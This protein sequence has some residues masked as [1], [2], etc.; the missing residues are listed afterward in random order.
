MVNP[1]IIILILI[2]IVIIFLFVE[3]VP[4]GLSC[5]PII[6]K[7]VDMNENGYT[8]FYKIMKFWSEAP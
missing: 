2:A 4:A 6:E 5:P 7:C 3:I 1:I 8:S